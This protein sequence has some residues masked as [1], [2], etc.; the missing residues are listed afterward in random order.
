[1]SSD[2]KNLMARICRHSSKKKEDEKM[3]HFLKASQSDEC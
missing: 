1:M 2:S 3:N